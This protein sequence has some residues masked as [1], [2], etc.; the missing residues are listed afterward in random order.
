[1][2]VNCLFVQLCI[3]THSRKNM[4]SKR[5][6][7]CFR[8]ALKQ[9]MSSCGCCEQAIQKQSNMIKEFV[10]RFKVTWSNPLQT[11]MFCFYPV[12]VCA[13]GGEAKNLISHRVCFGPREPVVLCISESETVPPLRNVLSGALYPSWSL[14]EGET[15]D[16]SFPQS[17]TMSN[18]GQD[19]H[20]S[21]KIQKWRTHF[22]SW[23]LRR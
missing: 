11:T 13:W 18:H 14:R 6:R 10:P 21:P 17:C 20:S 1:M 16:V 4:P 8:F 19:K 23:S 7:T 5:C 2:Q 12:H 15:G 9:D 3:V 22:P